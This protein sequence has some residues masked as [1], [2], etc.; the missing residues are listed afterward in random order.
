[1]GSD[2]CK[3]QIQYRYS[4]SDALECASA[5]HK[6][7]DAQLLKNYEETTST[8]PKDTATYLIANRPEIATKKTSIHL[9][10]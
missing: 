3:A 4:S 9:Y 8:I 6:L 10:F 1:M 5:E 7:R 2:L